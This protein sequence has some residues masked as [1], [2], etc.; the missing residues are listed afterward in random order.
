MT[1]KSDFQ[2]N[3]KLKKEKLFPL[4]K[5]HLVKKQKKN[6]LKPRLMNFASL[7]KKIWN[8]NVIIGLDPI[9]HVQIADSPIKSGNDKVL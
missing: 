9:I 2:F 4:L 8:F 6:L 5:N 3:K 1:E 7:Q